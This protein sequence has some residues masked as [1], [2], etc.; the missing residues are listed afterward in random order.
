MTKIKLEADRR[1]ETAHKPKYELTAEGVL[2]GWYYPHGMH[3]GHYKR[4]VKAVGD[5]PAILKE[6]ERWQRQYEADQER[7]RQEIAKARDAE[8]EIRDANELKAAKEAL[9]S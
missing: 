5:D 3:S 4:A 2:V 9:F 6:C 1:Q 8:K 7:K